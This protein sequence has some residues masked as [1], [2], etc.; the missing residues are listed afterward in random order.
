MKSPRIYTYKI[1]FPYQGWW[2]WGVHKE[3]VHGEPYFGSPTTHKSKWD[4]FYHE[5]QILEFFD[6]WDEAR[7]VE[8]RL[9]KPDLNNPNCL[10]ENNCGG[11]SIQASKKGCEIGAS[12]GG[13]LGG[14]MPWWNNG[15]DNTRSYECPGEG[16]VRGS[17]M[18]WKWWNNGFENVRAPECPEGYSRGR[19]INGLFGDQSHNGKKGGSKSKPPRERPELKHRTWFNNGQME[20]LR[21]K[22]PTNFVRGRLTKDT[23]GG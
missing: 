9:I 18:N 17:L 8:K 6:S 11:F 12:K 19:L 3:K 1:T 22:Q 10:N 4:W 15:K 14:P 7:I 20:V 5:I 23:T 2:Y 16:W 21:H 13:K